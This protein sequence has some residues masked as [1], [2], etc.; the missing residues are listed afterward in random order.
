MRALDRVAETEAKASGHDRAVRAELLIVV[1]QLDELF[2]GQVERGGARALRQLLSLLVD[3]GRVWVIT[4]LRADLYER[5]LKEPDL[6][7]LKTEGA[8]YDLAPP[9]AAEIEEIIRGPAGAAGLVYET[10]AKTGERLDERLLGDIDR[11]DMLPL[12]QFTL[13]FLFE[14]RVTEDGETK[15][16]LKAY[17]ELGG[18]AGAIDREGERAIAELG[19][20]E[21]ERLPRLLR[22]LATPAHTPEVQHGGR[23]CRPLHRVGA[24][25][26]GCP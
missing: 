2:A 18:L 25:R 17:D 16:T 26:G 21:Q 7:A 23:I 24:V 10:D 19:A 12:L 3:T 14:N 4:T 1:D 9:G 11:P 15:L 20:A 22:Q 8:T 6:L 5:F 13:N